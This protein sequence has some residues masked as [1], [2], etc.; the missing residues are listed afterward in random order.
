MKQATSG[1]R[2]SIA[3]A[4][5]APLLAAVCAAQSP[6]FSVQT[7]TY[8]PGGTGAS[9]S[10][11]NSTGEAVGAVSGTA[12]C[13]TDCA[14]I[15]IDGTP[16]LLGALAGTSGSA[17]VSVNDS[18]QVVGYALNGTGQTQ[19][20][21]IW[22]N[23]KPTVL[24]PPSPEDTT[25]FASFINDA[26]VVVGGAS[27]SPGVNSTPALWNGL[28]PTAL[29]LVP[30]YT[31]GYASGV[32][33]DGLI[34]GN[35]CCKGDESEATVWHGTSAALLPV[36]K[37]SQGA[38]GEALAVNNNGLVVGHATS[39]AVRRQAVAWVD[40]AIKNL[41]TLFTSAAATAVNDVGIIVGYSDVNDGSG[42]QHAVIWSGVGAAPEDLNTLISAGAA[43]QIVLNGA[44][45]INDSCA[46]VANGYA[47]KTGKKMAFLLTL[48]DASNCVSGFNPNSP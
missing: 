37:P 47:K 30:G 6:T 43:E 14:A 39:P 10:G 48:S 11:I 7:L 29:G 20:A 38:G 45:G 2:H 31:S 25:S 33:S 4:V 27:T 9:V 17:A 40:G 26:G 42:G 15:W 1:R 23:G 18:G 12:A 21:V 19:Q 41:G 28:V 22:N 36:L 24:P 5:A 44:T 46:I 8:I 32:N 35:N 3:F 13:A 16:T 34:V